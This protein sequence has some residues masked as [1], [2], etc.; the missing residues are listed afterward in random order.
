M[1]F[2]VQI[3]LVS[4]SFLLNDTTKN[5]KH[6]SKF[7]DNLVL[8]EISHFRDEEKEITQGHSES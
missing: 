1:D 7:K 6:E 4:L 2:Y 8:T 3:Q 5:S